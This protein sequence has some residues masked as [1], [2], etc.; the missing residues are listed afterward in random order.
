MADRTLRV[1]FLTTLLTLGN[2]APQAAAPAAAEPIPAPT[3]ALKD[4]E[5]IGI[6]QIDLP[7]SVADGKKATDVG[8]TTW[9]PF[10]QGYVRPDQLLLV[11]EIGGSVQSMLVSGDLERIYNPSTGYVIQRQYK[12]L[13]TATENPLTAVQLS[14]ATYAKVLRELDTG[15]L[16]PAEDL[17]AVKTRLTARSEALTALRKELAERN[18][19]E[20]L[21]QINAAAAEH[22][23]IRDDLDQI[24]LRRAHP[25]HVVEFQNKDLVRTL[26]SRGLVGLTGSE[27]LA[28]GKTT[29]WITKA[30]GLP[31]KIETTDNGGRMAL[32]LC[33]KELRIN[34]GLHPNELKLGN[35]RGTRLIS[36][37][38]DL[39]DKDWQ[40]KME[41]SIS[42][43]IE[44]LERASRPMQPQGRRPMPR[45]GQ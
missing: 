19:P 8:F 29:V 12:N 25:C 6:M 23:R 35:P 32:F 7:T 41:T 21:N 44:A 16:L 9:F 11:L 4:Y 26:F 42:R 13:E 17:D 15:K 39:R 28:K 27:I 1:L 45:R 34:T 5:G 40:E 24:E 18:R 3:Q 36:A 31:I 30:E 38:A 10:R 22:S 14:M 20:D 33:F 43:Q 2:L 37:S